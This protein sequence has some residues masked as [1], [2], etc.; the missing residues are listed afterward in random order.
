[1]RRLIDHRPST[2]SVIALIALVVALSGTAYAASRIGTKQLRNGAVTSDKIKDGA[3]TTSKLADRAVTIGKLDLSARSQ[4]FASN[5]RDQL[6]LP[7]G[8]DTT[9]ARLSLPVDGNYI[10]TAE[11]VLG[12]NGAGGLV[13]CDLL[14]NNNPIASGNGSLTAMAAFSQ[15]ITLTAASSGGS[16]ALSCNPDKGAQAKAR[17]ITAVRVRTL[18]TQ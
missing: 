12:S 10:V 15:T 3:V 16:I 5:Q 17:V 1:M 2:A 8:T 13:N 4:G 7:G 11:T 18:S 14:E 6:A 9:V